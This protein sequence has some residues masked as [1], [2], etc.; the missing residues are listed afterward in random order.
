MITV[1]PHWTVGDAIDHGDLAW[2]GRVTAAERH[3]VCGCQL[4]VGAHPHFWNSD[5]A[6]GEHI[7][8]DVSASEHLRQLVSDEFA[9]AQ[10]ALARLR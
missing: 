1:P 6:A 9:D 8:V 4:Q 10:L 5:Q 7:I 3:N 2:E